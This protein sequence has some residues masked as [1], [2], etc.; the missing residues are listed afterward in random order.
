LDEYTEFTVEGA[1]LHITGMLFAQYILT[2][3]DYKRI[4]S[5]LHLLPL[6]ADSRLGAFLHF[7]LQ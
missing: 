3:H 7:L 5:K 1:A 4:S 2:L 6:A